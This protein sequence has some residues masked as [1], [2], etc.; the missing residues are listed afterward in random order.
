M[1]FSVKACH[2]VLNLIQD[3]AGSPHKQA[4]IIRRLRVKPAMTG[5]NK[6]LKKQQR[7]SSA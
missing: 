3:H 6:V 5:K 2:P 4:L 7:R 1:R